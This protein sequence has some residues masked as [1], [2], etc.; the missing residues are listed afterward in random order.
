MRYKIWVRRVIDRRKRLSPEIS[1][2]EQLFDR[3]HVADIINE[4]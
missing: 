1:A 2:D 3:Q 4:F